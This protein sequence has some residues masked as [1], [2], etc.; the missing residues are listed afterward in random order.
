MYTTNKKFH[1]LLGPPPLLARILYMA[2]VLTIGVIIVLLGYL[3]IRLIGTT[4]KEGET[5]GWRRG[6]LSDG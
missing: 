2:Q 6:E 5:R 3:L 1:E 4:R